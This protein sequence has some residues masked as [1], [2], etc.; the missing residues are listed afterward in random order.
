[1]YVEINGSMKLF[2]V[3]LCVAALFADASGP[4]RRPDISL[5]RVPNGGIQPQ[6]VLGRYGTLHLFIR[7]SFITLEIRRTAT[8]SM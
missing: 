8:C 1:M 2:F 5:V 3:S 6:A 7:R 4:S